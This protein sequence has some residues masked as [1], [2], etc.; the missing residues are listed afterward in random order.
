[1]ERVKT[2]K[3]AEKA[4]L[5]RARMIDAARE[6]FV[7]DGYGATPMQAVAERAGV[8]VQTLFY[9]FGT[10]GA[11]LKEVVDTAI[12]GD[13]EPVPTLER[14]WFRKAVGADDAHTA[15]AR[16]V[17]GTGRVLARVAAVTEMLRVAEAT[18]PAVRDLWGPD[19]PADPRYTVCSAFAA[20]LVA[21]PGAAPGADAGQAADELYA[22]LAPEPYLA[23]TRERGWPHERWRTWAGGILTARL[24]APPGPAGGGR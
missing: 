23:L 11:L 4:R 24:C 13:D 19:T 6:L 17:A 5:T 2:G 10:K 20:A 12:A 14:P 9:T 22:L 16:Y 1:M 21:K 8:A 3:R 18:D 7:A 15:L